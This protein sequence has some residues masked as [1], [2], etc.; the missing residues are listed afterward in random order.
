[1]TIRDLKK[2]LTSQYFIKIYNGEAILYAGTRR[3]I[4]VELYERRITL[5]LPFGTDRLSVQIV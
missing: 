2:M 3:N 4:P 5:I 1:M